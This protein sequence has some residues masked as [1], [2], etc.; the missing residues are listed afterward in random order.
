MVQQKYT[1]QMQA[2]NKQTSVT[3]SG[4]LLDTGT[5]CSTKKTVRS[6]CL[7]KHQENCKVQ[8]PVVASRNLLDTGTC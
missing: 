4:N 7:L 6:R 1:G 5:C 3:A 2:I 8:V